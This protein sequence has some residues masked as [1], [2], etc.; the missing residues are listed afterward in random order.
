MSIEN[1]D[2][3]LDSWK[4]IAAYL[5]RDKRTIQRWETHEG[6]PIHR[7]LHDKLSSVF[8]Y[9]SELDKWWEGS[10]NPSAAAQPEHSL[11]RRPLLAVLPLR[12]LCG[13]TDEEFFS[14]G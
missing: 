4:S 9:R 14:D 10:H 8:A 5:K 1:S 3:R 7:K 12:N 6:L 11:P 2:Q 13:N